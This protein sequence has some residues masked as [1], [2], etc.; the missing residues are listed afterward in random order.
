MMDPSAELPDRHCLTS[1]TSG[2][3]TAISAA[4]AAPLHRE[5]DYDN[6]WR[7]P[8]VKVGMKHR[9]SAGA[10]SA[11]SRK[12]KLQRC[13]KCGGLGHK[14]RTCEQA[15]H[16][17]DDDDDDAY[18]DVHMDMH[19]TVLAA[20]CLLK[21]SSEPSTSPPYSPSPPRLSELPPFELGADPYLHQ[22]WRPQRSY[23][24]PRVF[25]T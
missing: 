20:Y 14:S 8:D 16:K 22:Q 7:Y 17:D 18:S 25:A 5:M 21:M 23:L 12:N 24:S 9:L 15:V 10:S 4:S 1:A 11:S 6:S 13:S 3:K 19:G 2:P